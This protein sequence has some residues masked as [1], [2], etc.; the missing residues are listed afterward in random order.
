MPS[1]ASHDDRIGRA[2]LLMLVGLL[3]LLPLSTDLYLS[4]LPALVTQFDSTPAQVQLTLSVFSGGF[5]FSQLLSGPLSDR[6]G[7][8]PVALAGALLY[9]AASLLAAGA[10]ALGW[11]IAARFAQSVGVCCSVV[12]ARAIIRDLYE[13]EAG[14]RVLSRAM[15]WLAFVILAGPM[16]GSL[17]FDR[18]GWRACWIALAIV[19]AVLLGYAWRSL[20]ETNRHLAPQATRLRPLVAGYLGMLRS[21]PFVAFT[22]AVTLSYCCLFAFI[23]SSSFVLIELLGLPVRWYGPAFS[24][25]TLGF[26]LGTMAMRRVMPANG[27]HRTVAIGAVAC[28]AGGLLLAGFEAAG[29]HS[30]WA[31]VAPMSL[32][33]LGHGMVQPAAQMGAAAPFPRQA[34]AAAAF[35]GF[36][37]NFFAS[38]VAWGIGAM[39]DGSARPFAFTVCALALA[40]VALSFG[41]VMRLRGASGAA[42]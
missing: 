19:D 31:I 10:P 13:P 23:A 41:C 40:L 20:P 39:Y 32:V 5:A 38:F 35:T 27:L 18:F 8:R 16:V 3:G 6:Y 33:L 14:A 4:S 26:M 17:L 21:P 25:V 1:T 11:L 15:S 30:V 37:M 9:L 42:A 36:A 7:R 22:L 29:V 12:C 2:L 28:A 34:G 24:S